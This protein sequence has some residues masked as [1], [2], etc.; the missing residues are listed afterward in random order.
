MQRLIN[1]SGYY[2]ITMA[3]SEQIIDTAILL[4][5][6]GQLIDLVYTKYFELLSLYITI[7]NCLYPVYLA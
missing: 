1:P 3:S 7:K 6:E 2:W 4:N 5:A